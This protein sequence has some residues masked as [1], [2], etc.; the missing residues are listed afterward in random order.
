VPLDHERALV[1]AL[2]QV[3]RGIAGLILRAIDEQGQY[4]VV[5]VHVGILHTPDNLLEL[6]VRVEPAVVPGGQTVVGAVQEGILL[7]TATGAEQHGQ[8]ERP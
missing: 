8:Q 3:G 4:L 2:L 6:L 5:V 7:F 1:D